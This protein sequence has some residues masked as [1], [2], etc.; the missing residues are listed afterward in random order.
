MEYKEVIRILLVVFLFLISGCSI[1]NYFQPIPDTYMKWTKA[2]SSLDEVKKTLLECGYSSV[3]YD[4]GENE[5]IDFNSA[6]K[7]Q[8][9]MRKKGY[10]WIYGKIYCEDDEFLNLPAC[11]D[12]K[13]EEQ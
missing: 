2:G 9:C 8:L 13:P 11:K 10:L 5:V 3:Y 12:F 4:F 1:R 7:R 6:A